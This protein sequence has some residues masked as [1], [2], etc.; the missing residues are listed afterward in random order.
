MCP[1]ERNRP[2]EEYQGTYRES[3]YAEAKAKEYGV[4]RGSS[5]LFV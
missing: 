3:A 1:Y 5:Q 2:A 4:L